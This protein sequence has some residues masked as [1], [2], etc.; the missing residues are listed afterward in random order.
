[1]GRPT[2]IKIRGEAITQMRKGRG[3][4]R[5][6]LAREANLSISTIQK[7]EKNLAAFDS[8]TLVSLFQAFGRKFEDVIDGLRVNGESE[9]DANVE[10]YSEQPIVAEIP[11]FDLPVAAGGWVSVWDNMDAGHH[12]TEEQVKQGLFRVRVRGE[13]MTPRYPD[14]CVVEFR[15]LRDDC[16]A[17]GFDQLEI[18]RR[19]YVQLE[20]GTGTFKELSAIDGERITLRAT[21]RKFRTPLYAEV[22]RIQK[23]AVAVARVEME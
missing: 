15:C 6:T 4:S 8:E 21:N 7:I 12:V 1:M 9:V 20:D 10:P 13:S 22:T 14:G 19:Y 23:L 17:P 2:G 5:A 11:F 18:G 16:G 3:W